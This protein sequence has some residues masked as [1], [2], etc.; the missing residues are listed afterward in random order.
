ME[1]AVAALRAAAPDRK[2]TVTHLF[3]LAIGRTLLAMP[4][5]NR[6]WSDAGYVSLP[7]PNV[8]LAVATADGL[9][10]PV[11]RDCAASV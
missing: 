9:A 1:A 2:V 5:A 8:G 10:A 3:L 4:E 7:A 11:L 6:I